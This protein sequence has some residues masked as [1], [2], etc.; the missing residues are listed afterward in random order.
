MTLQQLIAHHAA[1]TPLG[2]AIA[3]G[4]R[5]VAAVAALD[6][7]ERAEVLSTIVAELRAIEVPA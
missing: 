3:A 1:A 7:R 6:D 2:A 5:V 4:S